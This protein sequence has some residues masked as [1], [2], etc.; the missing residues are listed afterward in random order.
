MAVLLVKKATRLAL[1]ALMAAGL[2]LPGTT[3]AAVT[4]PEVNGVQHF[5]DCF[6]A[7]L[8]HPD[9]HAQY[10]GPGQTPPPGSLSTPG[11]PAF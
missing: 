7:M 2:A 11:G 10:C 5:I 4:P 1:G 3:F 6:D 8:H 9:E